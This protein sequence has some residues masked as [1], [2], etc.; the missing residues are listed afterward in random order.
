MKKDEETAVC[1]RDK[2][3][4]VGSAIGNQSEFE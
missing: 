3:I 4:F 2:E 1:E